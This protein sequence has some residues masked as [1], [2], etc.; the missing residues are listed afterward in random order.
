MGPKPSPQV[1][2]PPWYPQTSPLGISSCGRPWGWDHSQENKNLSFQAK[3]TL[4][5][6]RERVFSLCPGIHSGDMKRPP[7]PSCPQ[8]EGARGSRD[9]LHLWRIPHTVHCS[10]SFWRVMALTLLAGPPHGAGLEGLNSAGGQLPPGIHDLD[11]P[12]HPPG[13][14]LPS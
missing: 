1:L 12:Y 9:P 11:G 2:R 13:H 3:V 6:G 10:G 14:F 8:R 5:V 4:P 7:G